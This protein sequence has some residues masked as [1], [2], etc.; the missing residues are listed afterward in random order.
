MQHG[1]IPPHLHFHE[2]SP[3]IPWPSFPVVIPTELTPWPARDGRRLAG[4]SGFGFSGT[5][6]HVV[7][8]SAPVPVGV[9]APVA[10]RPWSVLGLSGK[11][12]GAVREL[13]GRYASRL[14]VDGGLSLGDVCATANSGRAHFSHRVAL[15]ADT[16][17]QMR[18][19]LEAVANG[20]D[21][22]GAISGRAGRP[23]VAF[24]FTGQGSQYGGMARGLYGVEGV[25]RG[26]LDRCA[27]V[28]G[29][30][31]DESLLDV[32]FAGPGDRL[33][34]LLDET[35]FTQ[36]ALFAVEFALAELWRSWGVV[37]SG[38]LGHSVGEYVAAVLAGVFSVEDGLR[39]VAARGRLMQGL[40]SGGVM[41]AVFASVGEV[42]GVVAEVGG[43]GV[44]VAAVN[45]PGHVVVS[46]SAVGVG[47]VVEVFVGRGVR[48]QALSVSHAF[49][50][51]LMEPMVEAFAEVAGRVEFSVPRRRVVSNVTGGLVGAE[52]ADAGYWVRHVLAPVEFASGVATLSGL[53]FDA[54]VEV[55]PHPVLL[56]M[57][58][59]CV[60]SGG[61]WVPS[62]RRNQDD[63]RQMLSG[64]GA[65]YVAGV[66]VDWGA[67]DA[68]HGHRRNALPT[69]PFQRQHHWLEPVKRSRH[70]HR[71][72]AAGHP[73]LGRGTP[74]PLLK[75]TV[76][77]TEVAFDSPAWLGDHRL[78]DT[79]VFPGS[80]Y[81]EMA[82]AAVGGGR[83]VETLAISEPLVLPDDSEA[84]LQTVV[85]AAPDGA[86]EV[87]ILSLE[88]ATVADTPSAAGDAAPGC[89]LHARAVVRLQGHGAAPDGVVLS[90]LTETFPDEIDVVDYY[91]Q[92][93][94]IGLTYGPTFRG[95]TRLLRR[96]GAALGLATLPADAVD[97]SRYH[98]HPALLDACFHVLGAAIAPAGGVGSD[99]M[100]VPVAVE[101]LR[102]YRSG[103]TSIWCA[104]AVLDD[105][106]DQRTSIIARLD[107]YAG[108]GA[109]V[110]TVERLEVRRTPRSL[111][112]RAVQ[113]QRSPLYELAWRS[114]P[115]PE[116]ALDIGNWLIFADRNGVG[117]ELAARLTASGSTCTTVVAGPTTVSVGERRWQLQLD[118]PDGLQTVVGQVFEGA[119]AP[120]GVVHLWALDLGADASSLADVE[121]GAS[122][123]LRGA[124]QLVQSLAERS[125]TD[126]RL[127]LVTRG[128]QSLDG[129]AV[130][131]L[132]ATL[133]GFGRVRRQRAVVPAER[134][135]RPRA[136][137]RQRGGRGSRRRV[138]DRRPRE[139]DR[140][141]RW[142]ALRGAPRPVR[143]HRG[144]T[145]GRALPAHAR[146][147]G[148]ARALDPGTAI[149]PA[150]R[151]PERWRSRSGPPASTSVT[152]STCSACIPASRVRPV[153][154]APAS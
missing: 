66:D 93:R 134:L 54:F 74:V 59:G 142:A 146:R 53:G 51:P 122:H 3:Q 72:A 71:G 87:R 49:H 65:L 151:A 41:V 97:G 111:W 77:E 104:V 154:S 10:G 32:L 101:G 34:G 83:Y 139:P 92:L 14:D 28:L 116:Q 124:L 56:G 1:E 123:A 130:S 99:D 17:A 13:A 114:Q 85:V 115:P 112:Q 91:G 100:F 81:M 86:Q 75:A 33:F 102:I 64:L 16:S 69:Y 35:V 61:V 45:G 128:A 110:A 23:N 82:L 12:D 120:I 141:P 50:S 18:S 20:D 22:P 80:A 113:D 95:L 11:S 67:V 58:Q 25:F 133:W 138:A 94:S 121:D 117:E 36:P 103:E 6:A 60:G 106:G 137:N 144:R 4:V 8:E 19:Q 88:P 46:G 90:E 7:L 44:S 152:C 37:P 125:A 136:G 108:D 153:S 78:S 5:N 105:G 55:G 30:L 118:E 15:V 149:A 129:E 145:R 29:S 135:H 140:P 79:V 107:L 109:L 39:L 84:T 132:Q 89:T 26:A 131:P 27:G 9:T 47:A 70:G 38:L 40:P 24:L 2:R 68:G 48:V 52:L 127:W 21:A 42:A 31:L 147:Q 98:I 76:F 126:A 43:G 150:P 73:L 57:A 62:L 96:D 148:L 119:S 143:R 63:V